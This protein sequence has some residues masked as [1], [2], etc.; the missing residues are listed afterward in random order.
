VAR[1]SENLDN[2]KAPFGVAVAILPDAAIEPTD[3]SAGGGVTELAGARQADTLIS[4]SSS[5]RGFVAYW[6]H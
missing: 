3:Q 5:W 1:W 4:P 6:Q 2:R